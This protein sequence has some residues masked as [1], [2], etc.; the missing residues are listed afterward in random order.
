MRFFAALGVLLFHLP[1]IAHGL[2]GG[3]WWDFGYLGVPFFFALSGFVLT[4]TA[5][6]DDTP[7]AFWRRR[8][9]RIYPLYLAC[10]LPGIVLGLGGQLRVSIDSVVLSV[11]M[12]QAWVPTVGVLSHNPSF[13]AWSIS[14]EAFFY[15]LFPLLIVAVARLPRR[16]LALCLV[17]VLI[18]QLVMLVVVDH[19][20]PQSDSVPVLYFIPAY[21]IGTFVAGMLLAMA[22]KD[23]VRFPPL[24]AS[25]ALAVALFLAL[26]LAPAHLREVLRL[27]QMPWVELLATP[28]VLLVIGSAAQTDVAGRASVFRLKPLV[29]LGIWSY[30]L[31]L[32]QGPLFGVLGVI[33]PHGLSFNTVTSNIECLLLILAAIAIAALAHRFIEMPFNERLRRAPP[34]VIAEPEYARVA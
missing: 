29:R 15:A 20:V 21:Q 18:S 5:T 9:A 33:A 14:A 26:G 17:V 2:L 1:L 10:L 19:F 31:Y 25:A 13:P 28:L 23:G 6:A 30:A 12:L 32:V 34:A 8:F 24:R 7:R 27:D 22:V 4:W 3:R 16:R 11:P